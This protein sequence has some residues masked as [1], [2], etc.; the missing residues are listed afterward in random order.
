MTIFRKNKEPIVN[1]DFN[2]YKF[3]DR[4]KPENTKDIIVI[5]CFSEFGCEIMS[6]LYCIPRIIKENPNAYFIVMGWY[7]RMYLYKHLVDEYWETKEEVQWLRD[8]CLAFHN[9]SRN[10]QKLE[11]V[12][13]KYGNVFSSDYM[14]RVTVGN[15]CLKCKH[16]WGQ[17]DHVQFCP[18]CNSEEIK[19][20]LFAD[21]HGYKKTMTPVPLPSQQKMEQAKKFLGVNPVGIVARNRST[22]GRNLQPEFYVKLIKLLRNMGYTPIWF[23]EKQS[24]LACPAN[25]II[26]LSRM[27]EA[28]DLELTLAIIKQLNF[29][30]QFWT[31]S[32]RLAALVETP[33][34]IFESPD[35]LFGQGQEAY[36]LSLCTTGKAKVVLSHYLSV[37]NNHE[38][39][40]FLV[41]KCIKEM[42]ADNWKMKIGMV[43]SPVAVSSM[44]ESNKHRLPFGF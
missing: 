32:T 21:V 28:R 34:I 41:Q 25:D 39:A 24:T 4:P 19:R 44:V 35:Q 22:Y 42:Q 27:P 11:K 26:D 37:Y 6:V 14:G 36:R 33:Y 43:D 9:N 38:S 10:L 15:N 12:A 17:S 3:T 18:K 16:F 31:A 1:I 40:M 23:G 2:I 7:G 5:C 8:Y 29:T 30:V 13:I 20:G